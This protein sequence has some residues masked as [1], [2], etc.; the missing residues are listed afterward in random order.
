[1]AQL[2]LGPML[3]HTGERTAA[4]WVET[5][6]PGLVRVV[7]GPASSS[8]GG[9]AFSSPDD[10]ASPGGAPR[11]DAAAPSPGGAARTFT[12]HGHHYALV[13]V[14]GLTPGSAT[15]YTV[16]LDGEQV[17]PV[18]GSSRPPSRIRTLPED[19][20]RLRLAFGSCR[21]P[22]TPATHGHDALRLLARRLREAPD[23]DPAWPSALLLIGDQVYADRPPAELHEIAAARRDLSEPPHEEVADFEEYAQLYRLAWTTDEEVRWLLSTVPTFMIFD[24][25]DIRDDW[26]TSYAWR[27]AMQAAPWWRR[28]IV[29]GLGAYWL[30][31][32]LG[33]LSPA[34]RAADPV[35]AALTGDEEVD[36]G[37]VLDAFAERTDR[38]PAT[39]RWSYV[40]A[41]GRT[42]MVAVDTRCG[43]VLDPARRAMLDDAEMSWVDARI[44]GDADHLLIVSSL[45]YL[46]PAAVHHGEAWNE[47]LC[48]SAWGR[49]PVKRSE[50]LRQ[51]YDLEHWAAFRTSFD[52]LARSVLATANGRRGSAPASITFL[53]GDV[54][55]SYTAR[56][57]RPVTDSAITQIVSSPL[58]NPLKRSIRWINLIAARRF[59]GP[60]AR[61]VAKSA[62]VPAPPLRWRLDGGLRFHNAIA[63]IDI[64]GRAARVR[65][66][67][68]TASGELVEVAR[69]D[70]SRAAAGSP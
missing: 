42:R 41:F 63:T 38:D 19:A 23:E 65:W 32:H 69:A 9:T 54:H 47:A 25:H 34:E 49:W 16:T 57:T 1:M 5:D 12:V 27:Q 35:Y 26:N 3:R 52:A 2:I 62:G 33:N 60:P 45:P 70:L 48:A 51:R 50:W 46:L 10:S 66:D 6:R 14:N 67:A 56:V 39:T 4:V 18:P 29:G 24:D 20:T 37:A 7:C 11:P 68:A 13:E 43:R 61:L 53:S 59:L 31:Q 58:R 40:C 64:D 21:H 55:F 44:R 15:P 36:G 8:G 22:G 17:W 28:R 30:Y